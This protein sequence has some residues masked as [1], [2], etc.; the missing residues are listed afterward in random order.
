M[1]IMPIL[2]SGQSLNATSHLKNGL[3][4]VLVWKKKKPLQK[5]FLGTLACEP[6][7]DS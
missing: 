2:A 3:K 7:H 4:M 5:E 1:S 6:E